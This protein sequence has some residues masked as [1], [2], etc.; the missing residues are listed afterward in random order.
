MTLLYNSLSAAVL[1]AVIALIRVLTLHRLPKN[2]FC[3][4]WTAA[5]LRLLLPF[6]IES[7]YSFMTFLRSLFLESGNRLALFATA[8]SLEQPQSELENA[9]SGSMLPVLW[10]TGAC[11]LAG[12]FLFTYLRAM[13]IFRQAV[14]PPRADGSYF[15]REIRASIGFCSDGPEKI[16]DTLKL[17]TM[18]GEPY[19]LAIRFPALCHDPDGPEGNGL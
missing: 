17:T 8:A 9:A 7:E 15:P 18:T 6:S 11:L 12:A 13:R 16:S 14:P 10:M 4:L 5:A 3:V 1:I 2:T 19:A